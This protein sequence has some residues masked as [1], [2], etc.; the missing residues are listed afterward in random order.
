MI[1]PRRQPIQPDNVATI[2]WWAPSVSCITTD[3]IWWYHKPLIQ[4]QHS[5]QR[6]AVLPLE[7]R[8]V[9]ATYH[10]S[11]TASTVI[12]AVVS[13]ITVTF[14]NATFH[15]VLLRGIAGINP[16]LTRYA[17]VQCHLLIINIRDLAL[18]ITRD[19][20][21]LNSN[22]QYFHRNERYRPWE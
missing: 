5:F 4:W 15:L 17:A 12:Q 22:V 7:Q 16:A 13:Q 2:K 20:N 14:D 11:I 19:I 21:H 3:M 18:L 6:K 1:N 10:V 9:T 8:L